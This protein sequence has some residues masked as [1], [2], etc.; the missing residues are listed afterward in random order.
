[1][2]LRFRFKNEVKV[3]GSDHNV[4]LEGQLISIVEIFKYYSTKV[5]Q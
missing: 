4:R 3:N 5:K 1:M 2:Q